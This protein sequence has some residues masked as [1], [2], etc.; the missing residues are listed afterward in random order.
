MDKL[1]H[2]AKIRVRYVETDKMGVVNNGNYLTYFEVG[3][4]ELMRS[5]NMPYS[6]LEDH[7][8]Y[9][10]LLESHAEYIKTANYDDVLTIKTVLSTTLSARVRFD[11]SIFR[12]DDLLTRGYTIHCFMDINSMH[13]TRPPRLFSD[14][15]RKYADTPSIVL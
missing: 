15:L 2:T 1:I 6:A 5:F 4:T 9:F 11:Y 3:R 8:F 7:G 13:A 10:P 12:G 14:F